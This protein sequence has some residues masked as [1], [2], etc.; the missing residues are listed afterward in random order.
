[1]PNFCIN[2]LNKAAKLLSISYDFAVASSS[3]AWIKTNIF[4]YFEAK[5]KSHPP[6]MRGLKRDE[7]DLS[8]TPDIV[9]SSSD[10]WI[11]TKHRLQCLLQWK[12]RI[13]LGCVD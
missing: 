2:F 9:A 1:M 13:L 8:Y 10:A 12:R 3:D 7:Y 5:N 6:R 4:N 11:K